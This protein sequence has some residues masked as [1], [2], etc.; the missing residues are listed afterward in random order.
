MEVSQVSSRQRTA[1][2]HFERMETGKGS[3]MSTNTEGVLRLA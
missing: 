1:V 3:Q 2:V